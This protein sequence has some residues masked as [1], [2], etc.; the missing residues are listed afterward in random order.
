MFVRIE[1]VEATN[2][3]MTMF[4]ISYFDVIR[5]CL[6]FDATP[7]DSGCTDKAVMTALRPKQVIQAV[8]MVCALLG[9][10]ETIEVTEMNEKLISQCLEF[11]KVNFINIISIPLGK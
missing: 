2:F 1:F 3:D 9:K 5:Y 4:A 11:D 10:V 8:K 7:F 6:F